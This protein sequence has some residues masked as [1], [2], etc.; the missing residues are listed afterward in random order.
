M[1][2]QAFHVVMVTLKVKDLST[3]FH[4]KKVVRKCLIIVVW[5]L[6]TM[7]EQEQSLWVR[8]PKCYIWWSIK[9]A[10]MTVFDWC[11][12]VWH[13]FEGVKGNHIVDFWAFNM[14]LINDFTFDHYHLYNMQIQLT[15]FSFAGY[16]NEYLAY[17]YTPFYQ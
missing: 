12:K 9:A 3:K 13:H 1:E 5:I 14:G 4:I 15:H 6:S 2:T 8:C 17:F 11:S 7:Y 16:L 10:E